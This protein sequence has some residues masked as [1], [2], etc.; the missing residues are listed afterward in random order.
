[1][2]MIDMPLEQ[3]KQYQ[4]INPKPADFDAYWA[5]SLEEMH[6]VDPQITLTDADF[7]APGLVC[8]DLWFTGVGGARVHAKFVRPEKAAGK[9]PGMC[10]FHGYTGGSEAWMRLLPFAYAG[11]FVAAMDVR[12]QGGYSQDVSSKYGPTVFGHVVNGL[13]DPDP[14]NLFFRSVFLDAAQ[15]AGILMNMEEVDATRVGAFGGSQGGALTLACASLEPRIAA[16]AP[17]F[18]WLCDYRRVWEMD[19]DKSAYQGL[20]D[21]FRRF[22]PTH[23]H[24]EETFYKLGYVDLQHLAPRI[25]GKV[26]M[27]TGLMDVICPPSTQFAAYNKMMAEKEM[28]IYPDFGHEYLPDTDER[29]FAFMNKHLL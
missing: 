13:N 20:Q 8:Q 7:A 25:R 4:G 21:Y 29:T 19:L 15:L 23:E 28:V 3:L 5:E 26:L 17:E 9:H 11:Y 16:L 27:L 14:K 2:P 24:A 12:G 1:M 22:D 10:V 18:P 6:A